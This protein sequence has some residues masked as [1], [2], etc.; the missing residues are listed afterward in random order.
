MAQIKMSSSDSVGKSARDLIAKITAVQKYLEGQVSEDN[1][2]FLPRKEV[3]EEEILELFGKLLKDGK[4]IKSDSKLFKFEDEGFRRTSC[5]YLPGGGSVDIISSENCQPQELFISN[6][7]KQ[8][9]LSDLDGNIIWRI[10]LDEP[11]EAITNTPDGYLLMSVFQTNEIKGIRQI[12]RT[13]KTYLSTNPLKPLGIYCET[14]GKLLVC[15]VDKFDPTLSPHNRR[16]VRRYSSQGTVMNSVENYKG[17]R[18]YRCPYRVCGGFSNRVHVIDITSSH[19]GSVV[20]TTREGKPIF[21]FD[22]G[23]PDTFCPKALCVDTRG[24]LYITDSQARSI[25]TLDIN[26]IL[27]K[28]FD[29]S[30]LAARPTAISSS[31]DS[32][33]VLGFDRSHVAVY[34]S[35]LSSPASED[36]HREGEMAVSAL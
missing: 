36:I 4:E 33:V 9:V 22:N 14:D 30:S 34:E 12:D 8:I 1:V 27:T 16:L 26:G 13:P 19:G 31:S 5:F 6:D 17:N 2:Q 21:T 25:Y 24:F 10:S 7:P 29:V 15:L 32:F 20:V 28:E 3:S 35:G 18:I 23:R 11:P